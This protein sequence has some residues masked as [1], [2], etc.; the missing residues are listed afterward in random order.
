MNYNKTGTLD[1]EDY[2]NNLVLTFNESIGT[3]YYNLE[4]D[5]SMNNQYVFY[6]CT[7][8][9]FRLP[10]EHVLE[11]QKY[12]MEIQINCTGVPPGDKSGILKVVFVAIPVEIVKNYNSQSSVFDNFESALEKANRSLP[13]SIKVETFDEVLNPFNMFSRIYFYTG[14]S[15]YP[16]CR[17]NANW[18]VI[19]SPLRIK[20]R[21]YNL[22]FDL[23]DKNQIDDGNYREAN[24]KLKDYFMLENKFEN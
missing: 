12:D 9:Y 5:E 20:E 18:I 2:N 22:L 17:I 4:K 1:L 10:G 7:K 19:E 16:K 21:N 8:I 3:I 6:N 11:K 13:L 15:N 24:P 14:V 23:L